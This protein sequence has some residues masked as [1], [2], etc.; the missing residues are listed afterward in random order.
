[1]PSNQIFIFFNDITATGE[2]GTLLN[3]ALIV[4]FESEFITYIK[5]TIQPHHKMYF[6]LLKNVFDMFF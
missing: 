5:S 6:K 4:T 1:M 2:A 3:I